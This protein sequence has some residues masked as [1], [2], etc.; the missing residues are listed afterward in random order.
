M[1]SRNSGRSGTGRGKGRQ[2]RKKGQGNRG[3]NRPET[4]QPE[5]EKPD[6]GDSKLDKINDVVDVAK[7]IYGQGNDINDIGVNYERMLANLRSRGLNEQQIK[8]AQDYVYKNYIPGS[9][10]LDR[11]SILASA[12]GL[13]NP[14][15]SKDK[16][17]Q[18]AEMMVPVLTHYDVASKML[19]QSYDPSKDANRGTINGLVMAMHALND[20]A[21]AAAIADGVFKYTHGTNQTID[22]QKTAAFFANQNLASHNQSVDSL[23]SVLEP[24]ISNLGGDQTATGLQAASDYISGKKALSTTARQELAKLGMA[25]AKD[26]GQSS[27][28]AALQNSDVASYVQKLQANYRAHGISSSA[29]MQRENSLLFGSAGSKV[30]NQIIGAQNKTQPGYDSA[31][32][33]AS[34]L[35]DPL[36]HMLMAKEQVTK[37]KQDTQ[38]SLAENA[39]VMTVFSKGED[40]LSRGMSMGSH[41]IDNHPLLSKLGAAGYV[42]GGIAS[43]IPGVMPWVAK[44]VLSL[45][46]PLKRAG[47]YLGRMAVDVAKN[48]LPALGRAALPVLEDVAL[49]LISDAALPALA[50]SGIG[51]A[52]LEAYRSTKASIEGKPYEQLIAQSQETAEL[53]RIKRRN[54]ALNNPKAPYYDRYSNLQDLPPKQGFSAKSQFPDVPSAVQQPINI[55]VNSIMD[56][57]KVG[58]GMVTF[59]LKQAAKPRSGVSGFDPSQLLIPPGSVSKI[60]TN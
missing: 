14:G 27:S 52:G 19:D 45:G 11:M 38:L 42:V 15:L 30:Y 18:A 46:G 47:G 8:Q 24:V 7:K 40:L 22:E 37:A 31:E 54:W 5:Q 57:K 53:D 25:N 6:E 32:G 51:L 50:L 13:F 39:G 10:R 44:K 20:P 16:S 4:R 3:S 41:F 59:L 35:N 60:A 48:R 2:S 28:L 29:A 36:S 58:E 12:Q 33:V 56:G 1:G 49:P 21:R 26:S 55:Q 34:V 43:K 17:L 9:S 23:F